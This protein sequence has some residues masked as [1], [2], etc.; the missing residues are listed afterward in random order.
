MR[1]KVCGRFMKCS[2][3]YVVLF[4][5][6][7]SLD[8]LPPESVRTIHPACAGNNRTVVESWFLMPGQECEGGITWT[9]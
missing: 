9:F 2:E 3:P 8:P 6:F 1:C 5:P 4:P 7:F